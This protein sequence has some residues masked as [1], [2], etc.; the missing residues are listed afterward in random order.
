MPTTPTEAQ[1][2]APTTS[3]ATGK[4]L[5]M[6]HHQE[7]RTYRTR[8]PNGDVPETPAPAPVPAPAP[9]STFVKTVLIIMGS[10]VVGGITLEV[11]RRYIWPAERNKAPDGPPVPQL[12]TAAHGAPGIMPIAMPM[13]QPM[14]GSGFGYPPYPMPY[15][16]PPVVNPAPAAPPLSDRA[17]V[18]IARLKAQEAADLRESRELDAYLQGED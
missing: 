13:M 4:V 17:Q 5:Q 15:P 9:R 8:N 11:V 14:M 12:P 2:D 10:A 6:S 1:T 16:P 7:R 3:N 18:E